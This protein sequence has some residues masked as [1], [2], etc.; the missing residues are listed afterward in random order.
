M[1]DLSSNITSENQK[2]K[3]QVFQNK[4]LR[5]C[6]NRSIY[7][8]ITSLHHEAKIVPI[9]S[10]LAALSKKYFSKNIEHNDLI[11]ADLITYLENQTSKEGFSLTSRKPYE[12]PFFLLLKMF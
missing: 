9:S 1:Q 6:L 12:T 3:L 4:A 11:Q 5:I 10:R 2:S 7:T 8:R